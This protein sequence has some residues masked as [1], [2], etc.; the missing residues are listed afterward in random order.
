MNWVEEL[1]KILFPQNKY[2]NLSTYNKLKSKRYYHA[3][4]SDFSTIV[5][6]I[7][8]EKVLQCS[9]NKD[10]QNHKTNLK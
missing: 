5:H 2:Q 3:K 4:Y 9:N 1:K 7:K 6:S 8:L 10:C